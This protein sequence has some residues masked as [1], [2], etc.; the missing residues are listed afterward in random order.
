MNVRVLLVEDDETYL[1]V[2]QRIVARWATQHRV[3]IQVVCVR[4]A[5]DGEALLGSVHGVVTD[6][7]LPGATGDRLRAVA[8]DRGIPVV[9]ISGVAVASHAG[10]AARIEKGP[11]VEAA[12]SRMLSQL[13]GVRRVR[14][15]LRR[16]AH[17]LEGSDRTL[18]PAPLAVA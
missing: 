13:H 17:T 18:T 2:L 16:F 12:V 11:K 9:L 6:H 14:T 15:S 1:L 10:R 3:I 7:R 8:E 4:T 5:E